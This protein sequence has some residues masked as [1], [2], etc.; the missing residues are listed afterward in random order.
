MPS[1]I[2]KACPTPVFCLIIFFYDTMERQCASNRHVRHVTCHVHSILHK[3]SLQKKCTKCTCV[4][5]PLTITPYVIRSRHSDMFPFA[6]HGNVYYHENGR[7]RRIKSQCTNGYVIDPAIRNNPGP[8]RRNRY[9][10]LFRVYIWQSFRWAIKCRVY[11]KQWCAPYVFLY[12]Y[13]VEY[14]S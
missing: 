3:Y 7:T 4:S 5:R 9:R 6:R 10:S 14:D 13:K 11:M 2:G 12:S 8:S 1:S